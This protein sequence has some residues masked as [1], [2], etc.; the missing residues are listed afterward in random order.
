MFRADNP[1]PAPCRSAAP[2]SDQREVIA[3]LGRPDSYAPGTGSVERIETHGSIV[4][5]TDGHA[6][7]LKRA[8]AFGAL[9]YRTPELRERACRAELTLNCRHTPDLYLGIRA[10][11]RR[12]DGSLGFDGG[13]PPL[14]WVVAMHRFEQSALFDR[15]AEERRL[16]APL[17]RALGLEIASFHGHAP[18]RPHYGGGIGIRRAI[19][20]NHRELL[21]CGDV[22]DATAIA[23]LRRESLA[24]LEQ[25]AALLEERRR[26]GWVRHCHGDLRLANICLF[27]GR[28]TLF[29]AIEF[30]D[31][32][33]SIDVLYD[34]A[35][36]LMDLWCRGLEGL[37]RLALFAY[38]ER[39]PQE[40]GLAALPLF[41]S[42]RAATRSYGLAHSSLRRARD[43]GLAALARRHL[44]A[45]AWF[46]R[47]SPARCLGH[48]VGG[49]IPV[50]TSVPGGR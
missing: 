47:Q 39:L 1:P 14:D 20:A 15:M 36:L 10:I 42:V 25:D 23:R 17:V 32:V 30:S 43:P 18:V 46:L 12:P 48:P 33:A 50:K 31:E 38:L 27:A 45:A 7:K 26:T 21:T 19:E 16:A 9:D 44:F 4:F 40:A 22:L 5:L 34:L 2:A 6:Y 41:L 49:L 3:F 28:P 13:A 11:G 24:R 35:F 37:A 29:D 8:V